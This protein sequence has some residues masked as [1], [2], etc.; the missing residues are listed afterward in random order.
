MSEQ[1]GGEGRGEE[2]LGEVLGGYLEALEAGRAPAQAELLAR[3]PE[4]AG[5][6]AAFFLQ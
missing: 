1:A 3:H 4:L 2:Q 6:L 5:E